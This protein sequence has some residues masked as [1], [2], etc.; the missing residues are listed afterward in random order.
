[1][2]IVS[3]DLA[4]DYP[5]ICQRVLE[6]GQRVAP[7]GKATKELLAFTLELTDPRKATVRGCNRGVVMAVGAAEALQLI[8]GFSDPAA[9]TAVS[10]TFGDFLD[11]GVFHAPYG[12]RIA[13]QV[14]QAL[15][16]LRNDPSTRQAYL[17]VWDPTQD[18]WTD[19]TRDYPCT[20]AIQ[21]M[22]RRARLDMHV[23]MRANDAWRGFPYDV[24]QFTQLQLALA[25]CLSVSPGTYYHHATS[26]HLYEENWAAAG[27]L[28]AA[29]QGPDYDGLARI[30]DDWA[31]YQ[32]RARELFYGTAQNLTPG[33]ARL[34]D[35]L[36]KKGVEG[37]W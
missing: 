36:R 35:P 20:T 22:I 1:M 5:G 27:G 32:D 23:V 24:F 33:E 19:R 14:P 9:M 26:F 12:P 2:Y 10:P 16:R 11:G 17:A 34:S 6:D 31:A 25:A 15:R 18:L 21:L 13:P 37:A 8:G 7:R 30:G 29:E 3:K 4:A 28:T